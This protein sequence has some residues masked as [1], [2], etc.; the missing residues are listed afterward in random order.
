MQAEAHGACRQA[1]IRHQGEFAM[2]QSRKRHWEEVYRTNAAHEVG[3]YQAHPTTSLNLIASTGV[4]KTG[5]LIDVG[6]GDSTLVDHLLDRG[7]EHL[8]VL[9]ISSAALERA[10]ARLDDRASL[11][12][13]IE[14]D[15]TDF[16]SSETYD[17]WHDRAVFHFFT[18]AKD[19]TRYIEKMDRV[20]GPQGHVILATF[21]QDA[22]PTCSGL[23]VM[24]YSPHDLASAVGNEFELVEFLEQPH[25][26]PGGKMQPFLYCRFRRRTGEMGTY[27]H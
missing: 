9:D 27:R 2:S 8:T 12:T 5:K 10:K 25:K 20:V 4:Q 3:W 11:V 23:P 6:G 16:R 19:R 14:S 18:E 13:W 1:L 15:V 22:P 24:R 17:V 21:G 26:T 7:F